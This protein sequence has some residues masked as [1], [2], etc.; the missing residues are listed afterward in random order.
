MRAFHSGKKKNLLTLH[1]G[2]PL[3]D[4]WM[5]GEALA[6]V[7]GAVAVR[8]GDDHAARVRTRVADV[9]AAREVWEKHGENLEG[10]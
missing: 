9:E 10:G 6:G 5:G 8:V 3:Y 2:D 1:A 7:G 4:D